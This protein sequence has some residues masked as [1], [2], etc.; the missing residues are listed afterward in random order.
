M[1]AFVPGIELARGFYQECVGPI[2]RTAFPGLAYSA[3]LIGYGS[4]V[5]GF[6]SMRSTD[7]QWGPRL[8][9]FLGEPDKRESGAALSET[10]AR[11]LPLSYRGYPTNF[12]P[13][14]PD[15]VRQLVE[16]ADGPVVHLIDVYAVGEYLRLELGFDPRQAIAIADWLLT[17]SQRLL[18]VTAGA[19]F[20]DG[21]DQ[22]E[23]IREWLRWYPHDVWLYLIACGWKRIA[24]EEAFM[25]RCGE[26]GDELG[27]R[28]TAG[29]LVRDLMRLCFLLERR[30]APYNKWLG[31]AFAQLEYARDLSP[32]F[33]KVLLASTWQEREAGLARSYLRVGEQQN[34]LGICAAVDPEPRPYYGRPYTVLHAERFTAAALAAIRDPEVLAIAHE[35]GGVDQFVDSTDVLANPAVVRRLR[36]MYERT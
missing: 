13:P 17:P 3:A 35:A 8:L 22:L 16:A 30:Y 23:R 26:A 12:G 9:L 5:L 32:I 18:H 19:V 21:L 29:R 28:L 27:S 20:H 6:D 34:A 1:P 25:G 11:R 36:A 2:L 4:D 15:G 7:H 14:G 31:T 10:L 33:E 24:Q